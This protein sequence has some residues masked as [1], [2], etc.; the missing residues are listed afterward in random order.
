MPLELRPPLRS[1]LSALLS[2]AVAVRIS[3]SRSVM[4]SSRAAIWRSM[5]GA[6][7]SRQ[8]AFW[9]SSRRCESACAAA[10]RASTGAPSALAHGPG[11]SGG[12]G[13]KRRC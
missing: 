3:R 7:I 1:S 13:G 6:S 12:A 5:A 4:F 11:E 8:L 2:A 9:T 10:S